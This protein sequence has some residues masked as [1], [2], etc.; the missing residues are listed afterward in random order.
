MAAQALAAEGE[1]VVPQGA[2]QVALRADE[3][4]VEEHCTQLGIQ[5]DPGAGPGGIPREAHPGP[6]GR[7]WGGSGGA[8]K[9]QVQRVE[10]SAQAQGHPLHH[11][12]RAEAGLR[13]RR[14]RGGRQRRGASAAQGLHPR[15]QRGGRHR[16]KRF[17]RRGRAGAR[18]FGQGC[19]ASFSAAALCAVSFSAADCLRD[20]SGRS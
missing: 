6:P 3:G 14:G 19:A 2:R 20:C 13:Q 11:A 17:T 12:P 18:L 5:D 8:G 9:P 4:G 16:G 7:R 1:R 15:V 10:G